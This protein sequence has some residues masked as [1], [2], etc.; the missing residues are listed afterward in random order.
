MMCKFDV[1]LFLGKIQQQNNC[2]ILKKGFPKAISSHDLE[3]RNKTANYGQI[4]T[5]S[6]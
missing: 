2:W 4:S 5:V 6:V 1:S 3:N